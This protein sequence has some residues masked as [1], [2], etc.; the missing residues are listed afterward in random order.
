MEN[1]IKNSIESITPSRDAEQRMYQNIL[2]KAQGEKEKAA[3]KKSP[4]RY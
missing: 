1:Q 3:Q 4:R 2:E